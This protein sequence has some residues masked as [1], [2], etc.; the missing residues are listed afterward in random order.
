MNMTENRTW[1]RDMSIRF[2]EAMNNIRRD[3]APPDVLFRSLENAI[4]LEKPVR[5]QDQNYVVDI[6]RGKHNTQRSIVTVR[7]IVQFVASLAC[8]G[9]VVMLAVLFT[10]EGTAFAQIQERLNAIR[11]AKLR[12]RQVVSTQETGEVVSD[13]AS[14]SVSIRQDRNTKIEMPD[15]RW[16]ITSLKDGKRLEVNPG[17]KKAS[18]SHIH[19]LSDS[20]DIVEQL[21]TMDKS[22][23]ALP[24][25]KRTIDGELCAGVRIEQPA[26]TLLVWV[27][28]KTQ[29]PVRVERIIEIKEGPN[30]PLVSVESFEDIVFDVPLND[31]FFSL[32][33][34][35]GYVVTESGK[36]RESL[37]EVFREKLIIAPEVGLG[38][39]Q[40]GMSETEVLELL[41]TPDEV[42]T[43]VPLIPNADEVSEINGEKR[44]PGGELIVLTQLKVLTY[45]GL[46]ISLTFEASAGLGGITCRSQVPI[47]SEISLPGQTME[48]I[49]LGSTSD[50]LIM[51]YGDPDEVR[52]PTGNDMP[53]RKDSSTSFR[54]EKLGYVFSLNE[55]G[56]VSSIGIG[57][58]NPHRLRFEWRVPVT[59]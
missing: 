17:E 57:G 42:V 24:L 49:R 48:G 47:T 28:P 9:V 2:H 10:S 30:A 6:V 50:E 13:S 16:I 11:S 7:R 12:Y 40:F 25:D 43:R 44:P 23:K 26:G 33:P 14:I 51:A 55:E 45:S 27:S 56:K 21:R 8:L 52:Y 20:H 32:D 1:E 36:P 58:E 38:P 4:A 35:L 59:K 34:P 18:V 39:L 31:Q 22:S 29:L 53:A 15:G 37:V 46:G 3:Q 5:T 41:G 19:Q 54:Y